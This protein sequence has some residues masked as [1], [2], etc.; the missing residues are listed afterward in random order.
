MSLKTTNDLHI[1]RKIWHLLAISLYAFV[2][3]RVS[4]PMAVQ[5]SFLFVLF[6]VGLDIS[7]L[8][9]PKLN[10]G[11][12]SLLKPIARVHEEHTFAGTTFFAIG[13]FVI[14]WVFP[15]NV[16]LL[17]LIL[18]AFADPIAS[19]VGLLYGKEKIFRKKTLQGSFAALLTCAL[20][21]CLYF[22]VTQNMNERLFIVSIL[23]GFIGSFA[24]L[25]TPFDIDDNFSFP[26]TSS[27]GL[28]GLFYIF[29]GL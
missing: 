10:K 27:I 16:A 3:Q 11:V 15:K 4:H 18:L 23:A 26:I 21:S 7:R 5:L 25:F 17:S 28:W 14:V 13:A 9:F 8:N 6:C 1:A 12:M 2:Y 19:A 20:V 22:L 29:G 24:E